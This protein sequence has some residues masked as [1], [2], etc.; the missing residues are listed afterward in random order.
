[1]LTVFCL[2]CIA[3]MTEPKRTSTQQAETNLT[4]PTSLYNLHLK[5]RNAHTPTVDIWTDFKAKK[6]AHVITWKIHL[7]SSLKISLA[8]KPTNCEEDIP[9]ITVK[10]QIQT[11]EILTSTRQI[12]TEQ[13]RT[14]HWIDISGGVSIH[15]S[16]D[17]QL[18][19]PR[20]HSSSHMETFNSMDTLL[21]G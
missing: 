17:W 10:Q 21:I 8:Q 2:C 3:S 16:I 15:T 19:E 7:W 12:P 9:S 11:T 1:M 20:T 18:T 14:Q 6:E 13:F 4:Q 5:K